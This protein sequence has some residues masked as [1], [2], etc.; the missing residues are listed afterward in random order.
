[1]RAVLNQRINQVNQS[2]THNDLQQY[3]YTMYIIDTNLYLYVHISVYVHRSADQSRVTRDA[4]AG[5][6]YLVH[7]PSQ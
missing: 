1:M 4:P 6:G 2:T 5:S 3:V 7:F